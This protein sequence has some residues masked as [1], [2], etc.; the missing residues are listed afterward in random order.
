MW[1]FLCRKP[2]F[3]LN[4]FLRS[5]AEPYSDRFVCKFFC[6][7]ASARM[8]SG[9]SWWLVEVWRCTPSL[10]ALSAVC[11]QYCL[12]S[13]LVCV[14]EEGQSSARCASCDSAVG[15]VIELPFWV[16]MSNS[17]FK[18]PLCRKSNRLLWSKHADV[19]DGENPT[20]SSMY[21]W[22]IV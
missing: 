19:R 8:C 11:L 9:S 15:I 7:R 6:L 21:L 16:W 18:W 10:Q 12:L 13:V 5:Q 20:S 22:C 3:H 4:L 2:W 1:D 17:P 14:E